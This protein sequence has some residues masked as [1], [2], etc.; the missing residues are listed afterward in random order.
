M[1]V[2]NNTNNQSDVFTP[3]VRSAYKF[4]NSNSSVD[5]TVMSFNYW[6]SLLKITMNPI[7]VKEGSANKVDTDNHVDIYLSPS[8]ARMFLHCIQEFRKNPDA[9]KGNVSHIAE[10]IRIATTGQAS[11]PD[12]WTIY[13]IMGEEMMRKRIENV[14]NK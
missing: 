4:F 14:L 10:I 13:H 12:Q 6:N 7:I 5:N 8:K 11:S 2:N 3:T 9:Y 1:T